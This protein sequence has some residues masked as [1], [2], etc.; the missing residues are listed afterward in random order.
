[1]KI[2]NRESNHTVFITGGG[3]GIGMGLAK[4][5]HS[6]GDQVI[7]GGRSQKKLEE[8]TSRHP[9]MEM[10][11]IDVASPASISKYF[12]ELAQL[13][14]MLDTVI[15]NAGVQEVIDFSSEQLIPDELLSREIDIN[16][17]GLIRVSAAA[18]PLLRKQ[19]KARLINIASSLAYIPRIAWP[20][21]S[22]TKAAV[23]SF[24]LS[25]REQL[26]RTNISVIEIIPPVV[27]TDLHNAQSTRPPGALKLD[28]F[29]T[30]AMKGLEAER[31]EIPIGRAKLLRMESRMAPRFFFRMNNKER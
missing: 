6:R 31:L 24:T 5:F 7:I 10:I 2:E 11:L 21:Y 22:A 18:L 29:V 23:H 19:P 17:K 3:S 12:I 20:I 13:Y 14:P 4:A 27:E 9:G 8:V 25:L 28:A 1:M 26:K 15:N 30:A 16:L